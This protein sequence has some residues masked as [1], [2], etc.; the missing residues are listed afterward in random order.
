[1]PFPEAVQREQNGFGANLDGGLFNTRVEIP[2][3]LMLLKD[4]FG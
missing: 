1:M 4:H 2:T 3:R